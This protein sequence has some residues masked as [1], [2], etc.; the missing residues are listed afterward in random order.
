M[1]ERERAIEKREG[2]GETK[3][4]KEGGKREM[5]VREKIVI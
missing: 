3:R 5:S 1:R 2:E 4:K